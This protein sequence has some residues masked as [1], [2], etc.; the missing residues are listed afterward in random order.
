MITLYVSRPKFEIYD[1]PFVGE[2]QKDALL[3]IIKKYAPKAYSLL[4]LKDTMSYEEIES[5]FA[6]DY[7]ADYDQPYYNEYMEVK[8]KVNKSLRRLF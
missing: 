1:E 5:K 6:D 4:K 3:A 7:L 2:T 8:I